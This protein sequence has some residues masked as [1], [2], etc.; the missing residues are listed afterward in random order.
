MACQGRHGRAQVVETPAQLLPQG[1]FLGPTPRV[2]RVQFLDRENGTDHGHGHLEFFGQRAQIA[3][4]LFGKRQQ[5]VPVIDQVG[6]YRAEAVRTQRLACLELGDDKIIQGAAVGIAGTGPRQD[7][8]P[9]PARQRGHVFGQGHGLGLRRAGLPEFVG[10]A[11][12]ASPASAFARGLLAFPFAAGGDGLLGPIFQKGD[13]RGGLLE[14][15]K[16]VAAAWRVR[17]GECLPGLEGAAAI[18][19]DGL[20]GEA[21]VAQFQ[22]PYAPGD[23]V[24]V[25][26]QTQEIAIGR[27]H[28]DADQDGLAALLDFIMGADADL[29]KFCLLVTDPGLLGGL[30]RA[31]VDGA[32]REREVEQ[33]VQQFHHAA[34]RTVTDQQQRDDEAS[35][36]AFGHGQVEKDALVVGRGRRKGLAEGLF[37]LVDLPVDERATDV[38][39]LSQVADRMRSCKAFQGPFLPLLRSQAFGGTG[40][41]GLRLRDR[42]RRDKRAPVC[43]LHESGVL[44]DTSMGETDTLENRKSGPLRVESCYPGLNQAQTGPR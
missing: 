21:A 18:T 34:L 22:Q 7:V 41:R 42:D 16:D 30:A 13:Q 27:S 2:V 11:Q 36:P 4:E 37:G 3:V 5:G 1:R 44:A 28:I 24:A 10:H 19:D 25:L 8:L 23:A 15:V 40:V 6:A 9:Q 43:F 29:G 26:F 31:V 14:G 32:H 20:G 17:Q 35:Q 33:V 12:E 39:F 38:V